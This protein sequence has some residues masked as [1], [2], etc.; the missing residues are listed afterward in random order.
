MRKSAGILL[1]KREGHKVFFFL[2]HHGGPFW[3]NKDLGA[4]SIPKGEFKEG[5]DPFEN[6]IREF[7]EET[8]F[9]IDGNFFPLQTIRQKAG[10]LVHAWAVEGNI[11]ASKIVSNTYKMQ[12]PPKSGKWI[13]VPEVDKAE[14]FDTE[15]ALK[16]INSAQIAFIYEVLNLI[17]R[18]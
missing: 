9:D 8:G 2:V 4:W 10:K 6:A 7:K 18:R 3:Q 15:T 11:D 16:K 14:W 12:W 13:E 17:E 5:D 1:F